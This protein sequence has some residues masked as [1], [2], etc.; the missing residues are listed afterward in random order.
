MNVFGMPRILVMIIVWPLSVG[1]WSS[2]RSSSME[3][4]KNCSQHP[5]AFVYYHFREGVIVLALLRETAFRTG[6]ENLKFV[7][8]ML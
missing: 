5:F 2:A 8:V 3:L 1:R 7:N 4:G 6:P